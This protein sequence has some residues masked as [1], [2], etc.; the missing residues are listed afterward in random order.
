MPRLFLGIITLINIWFFAETCGGRKGHRPFLPHRY[1][2]G[3]ND[4]FPFSRKRTLWDCQNLRIGAGLLL[5][6]LQGEVYAL[7]RQLKVDP[8]GQGA[9][10]NHHAFIVLHRRFAGAQGDG[11]FHAVR[12]V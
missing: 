1:I 10:I 9:D 3:V 11:T 12:P 4:R 6:L 2:W 8:L 5:F 7:H